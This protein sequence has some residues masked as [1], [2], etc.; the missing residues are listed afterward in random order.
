MIAWPTSLVREVAAR[1][2]VFFLGAGVSAT[3]TDKDG[4]RP[5][6]WTQFLE[7]ACKLITSGTKR[8]IVKKLIKDKKYLLALQGIRDEVNTAD[9]R[10]LLN[11]HFHTPSYEPS[12]LHKYICDLDSRIVITTN[13]DRIY[14][15]YC[16][17]PGNRGAYKTIDYSSMDLIDEIRSDTR[18]IIKAHGSIDDISQM[19]FTR[20]EYHRT[21]RNF[22]HFYEILKAIFLTHTVIFIGC[23]L[24]DPDVQ[25]LL[26]EVKLTGSSERPH[27]AIICKRSQ[28]ALTLADWRKT[29]NVEVLEYGPSHDNLPNELRTLAERVEAERTTIMTYTLP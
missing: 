25:L 3:A 22:P 6:T 26:E 13:F 4:K 8:K 14:E 1:R 5:K 2:C 23:S 7:E 12:T 28:D 17:Q 21:K 15:R 20:S 11:Q 9:Y 10:D 19:I 29:Y 16:Q 24:E 18:L 27:Y